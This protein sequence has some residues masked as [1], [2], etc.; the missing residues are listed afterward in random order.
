MPWLWIL[1]LLRSPIL[2]ILLKLAGKKELVNWL[3]KNFFKSRQI[4]GVSRKFA[5]KVSANGI[6]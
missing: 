3:K 2:K 1:K 4:K 6:F 5:R